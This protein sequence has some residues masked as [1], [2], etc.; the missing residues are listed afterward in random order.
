MTGWSFCNKASER[1]YITAEGCEIESILKPTA[2]KLGTL[3]AL[4][5][6]Q[7]QIAGWNASLLMSATC[8]VRQFAGHVTGSFCDLARQSIIY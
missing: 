7:T 8:Y 2:N 6:M 5:T 4:A 3:Q 1:V